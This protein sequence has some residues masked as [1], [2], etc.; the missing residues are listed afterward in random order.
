M[1][2]IWMLGLLMLG[3]CQL[4][5]A[6]TLDVGML[7]QVA[8]EVSLVSAG[9]E[10]RPAVS[11]LKVAV[12]DKL[13]LGNDARVQIVYFDTSHQELW[14]GPGQVEIGSGDGRSQTLQAEVK[15]LPPL[16]A[17][18]LIK[19]PASGQHGATGMV[20]VRSLSSDTIESLEKQYEEFKAT[21]AADDTT[22]EVFLMTGL[23]EMKEYEHAASVLDGFRAKLS[24]SPALA[25]VVDHFDPLVKQAA[26]AEQ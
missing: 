1:K 5:F 19:T 13:T 18:Q 20:T 16:V 23:L 22:P 4:A 10:K 8:G 21:A 11:F 12:G 6:L 24:T 3:W 17:R 26:T 7:T 2:R 25:A 9:G 14:K 15:K